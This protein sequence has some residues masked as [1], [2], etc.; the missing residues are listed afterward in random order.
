M[1]RIVTIEGREM[2]ENRELTLQRTEKKIGACKGEETNID[3]RV[4]FHSLFFSSRLY[5]G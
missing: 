3:R 1:R 4:C 2:D 5:N